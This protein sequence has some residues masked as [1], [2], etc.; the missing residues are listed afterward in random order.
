LTVTGTVSA[1]ISIVAGP[2]VESPETFISAARELSRAAQVLASSPPASALAF[3]LLA[4]QSAELALKSFLLARGVSADELA[5]QFGH[6]LLKAWQGARARGLSVPDP[7]PQWFLTIASLHQKPHWIRY[8]RQNTILVFPP[9]AQCATD[10]AALV[11]MC[12]I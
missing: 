12:A 10:L 2:H 4:G 1:H 3:A 9:L 6:D 5:P 8:P 11:E 7:P